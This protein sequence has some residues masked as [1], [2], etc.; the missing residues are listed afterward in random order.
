MSPD[1][2]LMDGLLLKHS[3]ETA[4]STLRQAGYDVSIYK[5]HTR[6][7][8][9]IAAGKRQ[10]IAQKDRAKLTAWTGEVPKGSSLEGSQNLLAAQLR[11]GLHWITCPKRFAAACQE[12]GL[13][14]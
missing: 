2:D 14:A 8:R 5:L 11:T 3:A 10:P 6:L 1:D 12:A 9:L 4:Y 13:V 7:A